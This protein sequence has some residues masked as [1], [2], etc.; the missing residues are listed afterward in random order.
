MRS[1]EKTCGIPE[2]SSLRWVLCISLVESW[3]GFDVGPAYSSVP[4]LPVHAHHHVVLCLCSFTGVQM[5]VT[6]SLDDRFLSW[7]PWVTAR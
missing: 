7:G 3:P 6:P 1:Y 5:S 4:P 2:P